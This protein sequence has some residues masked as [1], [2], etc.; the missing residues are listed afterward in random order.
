[1]IEL[2]HDDILNAD[3]EALINTVNCVGVMGRGIALQFRKAF[4]ANYEAYKLVCDRGEL[5]PGELFVFSTGRLTNPRYII[6]FATKD[7]WKG[8]SK[9]SYIESG[10][11]SLQQEIQRLG[12]SSIAIPP[13]GAG[14][15]G[16]NWLDVRPRIERAF[17]ALP[18]VRAIVYEPY[19]APDAVNMVRSVRTPKMTAGRAA[20]LGLIDRYRAALMDPFV[21]LLEIHKLMYFMQFDGENLKLNFNKAQYGPY[22]VNLRHVLNEI[23]GHFIQGYADG[24]DDPETQIELTPGATDQAMSSLKGHPDT[25]RRFGRVVDLVEGFET[26]FGMELLATVHWVATQE[27]AETLEQ[28]VESTRSWNPR[29]QM[30]AQGQIETAW[31]ILRK[32]GWLSK[33]QPA[34]S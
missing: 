10:L 2:K 9:L 21:S 26:P 1:M 18:D 23:E 25:H 14:L 12:I 7:H 19:G 3:V 20:L 24:S 29:K 33:S 32:K 17:E 34:D 4:P 27:G 16:L 8:N 13:L 22:A 6:N 15:G 31:N 28:V 5:H 11:Q 30:F